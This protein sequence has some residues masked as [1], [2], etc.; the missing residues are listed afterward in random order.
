[1][2]MPMWISG[3]PLIRGM[4][5][6]LN[7]NDMRHENLTLKRKNFTKLLNAGIDSKELAN[8]IQKLPTLSSQNMPAL[9]Y[10]YIH[11]K[12]KKKM[13]NYAPVSGLSSESS[14]LCPSL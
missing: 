13:R 14:A 12:K 10:S 11:Q 6:I 7:F 4:F 1:M 2:R 3:S 8:E 5:G 9:E